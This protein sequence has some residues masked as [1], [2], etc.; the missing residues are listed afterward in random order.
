MP[1]EKS[2]GSSPASWRCTGQRG[3]PAAWHSGQVGHG[4]QLPSLW[5]IYAAAVSQHSL[6]RSVTACSC[7][8]YGICT[9]AVSQH[10]LARSS[11]RAA[12]PMKNSL[13]QL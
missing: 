3:G 5:T 12:I 11:L 1:T 8:P 13:L 10:S 7:H 6:A 9:A 2:P 4:L